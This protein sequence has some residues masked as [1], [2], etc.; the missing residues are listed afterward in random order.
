MYFSRRSFE[1]LYNFTQNKNL[2]MRDIFINNFNFE[3]LNKLYK[4]TQSVEIENI[5]QKNYFFLF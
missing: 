1:H 5:K 3:L 2:I 4:D